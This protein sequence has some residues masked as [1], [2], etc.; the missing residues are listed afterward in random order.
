LGLV[1][2]GVFASAACIAQAQTSLPGPAEPGRIQ[3]PFEPP[4][5][6]TLRPEADIEPSRRSNTPPDNADEIRFVLK[7]LSITGVTVYAEDEFKSLIEPKIGQEIS[8][9]DL[10]E[11]ANAITARYGADGYIL[12]QALIPAQRI[13]SGV[14]QIEVVEGTIDQITF[15]GDTPK[16][17]DLMSRIAAHIREAQPLT[18]A[19]LERYLLLLGDL[20]GYKVRGVLIPSTTEGASDLIIEV[21]HKAAQGVAAVNNR[22]TRYIGPVQIQAGAKLIS[23]SFCST[24]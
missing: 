5:P 4:E 12:S 23:I 16:D 8:L 24:S 20:P 15:D 13:D 19:K 9:A 3:R 21:D 14:A 1:C 11:I 17:I 10:Y 18:A 6:P 2:A 7:G 22:G